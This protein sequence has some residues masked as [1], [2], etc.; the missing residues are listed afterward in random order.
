MDFILNEAFE[1]EFIEF[2]DETAEEGKTNS[3]YS[4]NESDS[5]IENDDDK[6][7]V[8]HEGG[9]QESSF[10]RGIDN[11]NKR[12]KFFNQDLETNPE[13]FGED[14][15]EDDEQPELFNPDNS[16]EIEFDSFENCQ[17]LSNIFKYSLLRFNNRFFIQLFMVL[18]II[19][20]MDRVFHSK[21]LKK[22]WENNFLSR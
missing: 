15:F 13:N 14:Y 16:E 21:K 1:D 3:E 7:F 10:Y 2:S 12:V 22:L 6:M 11:K 18:C 17:D 5:F 9:E 19:N 8:F 4:E 20:L